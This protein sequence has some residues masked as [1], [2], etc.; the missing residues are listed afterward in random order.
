[1]KNR[2]IAI[3]VC[4]TLMLACAAF[5]QGDG[6]YEDL[7]D[8]AQ[9]TGAA[10]IGKM[11]TYRVEPAAPIVPGLVKYDGGYFTIDLPEGW[12]IQTMGQYSAFSFRAWNPENPDY[13]IFYYGTLTPFNKSEEAK[14]WNQS[15]A[16]FGFPYDYFGDAPVVAPGCV[17]DLFYA[18]NDIARF[19]KKYAGSMYPANAS[20]PALYNVSVIETLPI[21]TYYANIASAEAVIRAS[22]QTERRTN[23]F[24]KFCASLID[25]GAYELDG[26]DMSPLSALGVSG[27]I[28][29]QATFV[30]VEQML[31]QAIY[32]LTF[33][34]AYVSEAN[35]YARKTG[36]IA[37][38]NNKAL[39]ATYDGYNA[40]WRARQTAYDI[41]SQKN[42]DKTLGYD[43]LYDPGTGEVYRAEV[44]F[45]DSYDANRERFENPNLQIVEGD[46][47]RYYLD[48]VQYYIHQ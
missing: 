28:A 15:K 46:A 27:V 39:Q 40:A 4:L 7:T 17:K 43:R 5:A 45:Y 8:T 36:E 37:M 23:G 12:R 30:E 34:D 9:P 32:S 13:E 33:T 29:P 1:M 3:W 2:C 19:T 22:L 42:S 44:G 10:Q 6:Y 26:V 25:L 20:F 24:G 18:W 35:E 14:A 31:T 21:D 47:E 48:S 41:I 38:A 16:G 11:G